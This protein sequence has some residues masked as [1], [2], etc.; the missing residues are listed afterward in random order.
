MQNLVL[1]PID[2]EILINEIADKVSAKV[3]KAVNHTTPAEQ[4][5]VNPLSDYIPKTEIRG[6]LASSS[7]LWKYEKQGKLKL[8]GI[9]GKR[10]YKRSDIANLFTEVKQK[11][12]QL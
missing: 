3:L 9:G 10:Y 5:P 7:T 12:F 6:K 1:S 8:Y 11:P 2:P 4:K